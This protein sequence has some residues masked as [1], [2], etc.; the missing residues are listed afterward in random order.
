[1]N[2][3]NI[4]RIEAF[5]IL[6]V[7]IIKIFLYYFMLYDIHVMSYILNAV[8]YHLLLQCIYLV[9]TLIVFRV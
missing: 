6:D 9:F 1:M 3:E 2:T 5:L 7:E 8:R 4:H